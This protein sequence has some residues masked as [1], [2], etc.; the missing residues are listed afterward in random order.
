MPLVGRQAKG[1]G[2][3]ID[4][5]ALDQEK[6]I[7]SFLSQDADLSPQTSSRFATDVVIADR[8]PFDAK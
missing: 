3:I 7:S 1:A 4:V 2:P 8:K 6:G 5:C